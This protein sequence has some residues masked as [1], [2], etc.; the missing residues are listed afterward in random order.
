MPDEYRGEALA[1]REVRDRLRD[2]DLDWTVF[3]P[4]GMI[5]PGEKKGNYRLGTTSLMFDAKGESAI[6][7]ED[8]SDALVNELETAAHSRAQFTIAY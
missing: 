3:C 2:S 8:Y 5:Q 4:P 6:S 1:M 7:A